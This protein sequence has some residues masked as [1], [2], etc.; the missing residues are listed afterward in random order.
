V[1]REPA[2]V[3]DGDAAGGLAC[4]V[5]GA[6]RVARERVLLVGGRGRMGEIGEKCDEEGEV[7]VDVERRAGFRGL[8]WECFW[9]G[10]RRRRLWGGAE[11]DRGAGGAE[12]V[13]RAGD[14][15]VGGRIEA[16]EA[17]EDAG[18]LAG[19]VRVRSGSRE[20]GAGC[21]QQRVFSGG[22]VFFV[23][24]VVKLAQLCEKA[25]GF[26]PANKET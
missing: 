16:R 10:Q 4:G 19:A 7:E 15:G 2:R 13:E 17:Q 11:L 18:A 22:R 26:D 21:T 23:R 25:L 5:G 9:L 3:A 24:G 20:E 8:C 12:G 1:L 6:G 14:A